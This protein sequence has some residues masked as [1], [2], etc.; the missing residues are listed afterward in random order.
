MIFNIEQINAIFRGFNDQQARSYFKLH[1]TYLPI[2]VF[3]LRSM[4]EKR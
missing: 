1:E 4:I 3:A 2:G